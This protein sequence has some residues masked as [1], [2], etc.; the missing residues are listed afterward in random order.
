MV[1]VTDRVTGPDRGGPGDL[2]G[3]SESAGVPGSAK[4]IPSLIACPECGLLAEITDRFALSSTDGPVE[5]ICVACVDG[6][7]FRMPIDMLAPGAQPLAS[8][9]DA[10]L[11][12]CP[13]AGGSRIG[14]SR[15][16]GRLGTIANADSGT[17]HF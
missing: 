14:F 12:C 1:S 11:G 5:H 2:G 17:Q 13:S 15:L 6:H 10:D 9:R 16:P 8:G 3:A 4:V 7:Y